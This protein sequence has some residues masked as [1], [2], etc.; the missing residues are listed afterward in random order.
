MSAPA[1]HIPSSLLAN[2]Q[3]AMR[4]SNRMSSITMSKSCIRSRSYVFAFGLFSHATATPPSF[5]SSMY[6]ICIGPSLPRRKP[7]GDLKT[8][9]A[10]KNLPRFQDG[11][12][13]AIPDSQS[14]RQVAHPPPCRLKVRL[15]QTGAEGDC[16]SAAR[17]KHVDLA[18]ALP[19]LQ[20]SINVR[21]RD[22]RL[23]KNPATLDYLGT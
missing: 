10:G 12:V 2:T 14:L 1:D 23:T 11:E 8:S 16:L 6:F 15:G 7:S 19:D 22:G 4:S 18:I 20:Y 9:L 3:T 5:W 21:R 17:G 13:P